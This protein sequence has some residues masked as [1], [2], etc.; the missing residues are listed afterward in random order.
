M[1]LLRLSTVTGLLFASVALAGCVTASNPLPPVPAH[2]TGPAARAQIARA[3][4]AG[5]PGWIGYRKKLFDTRISPPR[6]MRNPITGETYTAYCVDGKLEALILYQ[7]FQT[8][9]QVSD[10]N[11]GLKIRTESRRNSGCSGDLGPFPEL[12]ALNP[13]T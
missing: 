3:V 12:E 7:D 13:A 8:G 5:S 4:W 11:G 2:H 6:S 1:T 10:E 9:V